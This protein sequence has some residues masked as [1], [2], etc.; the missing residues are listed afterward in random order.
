MNNEH[1][2]LG[3]E[4]NALDHFVTN[5]FVSLDA[6]LRIIQFISRRTREKEENFEEL[7]WSIGFLLLT[8]SE[9]GFVNKR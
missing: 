7:L 1:A 9:L 3:R 2:A 4:F 6:I 8:T 5:S